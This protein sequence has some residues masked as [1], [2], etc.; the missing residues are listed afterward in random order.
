[1]KIDFKIYKSDLGTLDSRVDVGQGKFGK[2]LRSFVIKKT[3]KI[4]LSDFRS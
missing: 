4:I 3:E 2:N 1:M